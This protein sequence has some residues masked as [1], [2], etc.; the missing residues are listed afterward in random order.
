M[1][2]GTDRG[3]VIELQK[4]GRTSNAELALR[5]GISPAT[6]AKRV[7]S[8]LKNNFIS[9][10]ALPNPY[11]LGFQANALIAIKADPKKIT[12]ICNQ[13]VDSF[14]VNFVQTV[15]GRFDIQ[16]IV[17][18]PDWEMLH[19]F[20]KEELSLMEGVREVEPYFISDVIKRYERLFHKEPY[21]EKPLRMN[22]LE[23]E[24]IRELVNDGRRNVNALA[25]KLG[26]HATTIYRKIS[27]LVKDD[28]IKISAVPNPAKLGYLSNAFVALDVETARLEKICGALVKLEGT[29]LIITMINGP[30]VVVGIHAR[31]NE[32]L[33]EL[34]KKRIAP[35]KGVKGTETFIR[36][37]V[38]KRYY[39][40][41]LHEKNS[42]D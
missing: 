26:T 11:K 17:Y 3:L 2:S 10:R 32:T 13:L 41:F 31:D 6:V 8:L 30:T 1:N 35:M 29:H 24:I 25:E 36:A 40:W 22:S 14:H 39:G 27:S 5:L 9:I 33:Y 4:N 7:E 21:S 15:L 20:I 12:I 38:Y 16:L 34:V 42:G 18:F 37:E 28:I 19:H 23:G